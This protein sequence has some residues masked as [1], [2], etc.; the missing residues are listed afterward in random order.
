MP[1]GN[2]QKQKFIAWLNANVPDYP[3]TCPLCGSAQWDTGEI[4][5]SSGISGVLAPMV[6]LVCQS[7][8]YILLFDAKKAGVV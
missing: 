7:C 6:Q 4:I 5:D 1:M 2:V 3:G 8:G